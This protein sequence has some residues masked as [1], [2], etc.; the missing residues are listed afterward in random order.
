MKKLIS[1]V[2]A[3][4]LLLVSVSAMADKIVDSDY[5]VTFMRAENSA[6]PVMP[7]VASTRQILERTGVKLDI[8]TTV[9]TSDY[10]TKMMALYNS[11]QLPD[12]FESFGMTKREMVEDGA[13]LDLTDLIEEYA[14][15]IKRWYEQYPALYRTMVDGR[16]YSLPQV[17][18]DE[19]LE[20]GCVPFIRMDLLED[21]GLKEP[22]N[23]AELEDTLI[24]LTQKYG[25]NGWAARGTGRIIGDS[26]YSWQD[27]FGAS[28]SY[29][30][31][32]D[33]VWHIG[34]VEPEFKD[35][36]LYLNDLMKNKVLDEEWLTTTTA[37]WQEKLSSGKFIFFYDNPTFVS[38]INT[39]LSAVDPNARFAPL[40]LLESPYGTHQSYR[41]PT[42]Y[43]DTF[44]VSADTKDPVTLIK[45]LDWCYSDEGAITFGYGRE[46]ET[47][48]IDEAGNPQ[49]LP[50]ILEKYANAEDAYY[51][52]S[53]DMG[54]NNG[55]FCPAWMNL[56]IEVFRGSSNPDEWTAQ[57][58]HDYWEEYLDDGSIVEKTTLPPMSP[59]Q[60]ARAQEIKQ[61]IWDKGITEFTKFVMGSRSF[62]EYDG[63]VEELKAGGAE[64]WA[65]I[66]NEAEAEYQKLFA[67]E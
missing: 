65:D 28:F 34:M 12:I 26:D 52:A 63:F 44:Y 16:I 36:M 18:V 47:Y 4:A 29:Y 38:G 7:D 50:E 25:V 37:Q 33:G 53:S 55:Y 21:A 60:D 51:Q 64:E 23:W 2:L 58:M 35:A 56:T 66:L 40:K 43:V 1:I 67:N 20:V 5:T 49:W 17:R 48:Y 6:I 62:D 42:H 8:V 41:Q 45:F 19:N 10:N 54:V 57:R 15:N 9:G 31:D 14:P 11:N 3:L 32:K 30:T 24:Q 27:S 61:A 22:T 46:G 13:L 59:E 39:A